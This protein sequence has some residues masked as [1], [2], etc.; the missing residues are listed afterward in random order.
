M[1]Q[2][3]RPIADGPGHVNGADR[4]GKGVCGHGA[5]IMMSSETVEKV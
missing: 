2:L 5:G 4:T 1:M 3:S